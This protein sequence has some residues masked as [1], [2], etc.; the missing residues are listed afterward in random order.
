MNSGPPRFSAFWCDLYCGGNQVKVTTDTNPGPG[1]PKWSRV[2]YMSVTDLGFSTTHT[3]AMLMRDDGYL[4][5]IQAAHNGS[6][7]DEITGI[8]PGNSLPQTLPGGGTAPQGQCN[9]VG[10][11]AVAAVGG[12]I[13]PNGTTGNVN[14]A[15]YEWFGLTTMPYYG[16]A[17]NNLF[18]M[19]GVTVHFSP[20]GSGALP[21]A[22]NKYA[23][24]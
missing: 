19:P 11:P 10:P 20:A 7:Y 3:F 12:P 9:F 4:E 17:Y 15:F 6:Q 5:M 16:N 8:G 21:G 22:S 2:D 23:V 1:L 18:D 14:Q 13:L 24:Y